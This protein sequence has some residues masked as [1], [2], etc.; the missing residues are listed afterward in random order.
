[1]VHW[2]R[3]APP[4]AR[5]RRS[6]DY[7]RHH[8]AQLHAERR[9]PVARPQR[10]HSRRRAAR[11]HRP[12]SGRRVVRI[13]PL[14]GYRTPQPRQ[15]RRHQPRNDGRADPRQHLHHSSRLRRRHAA[16]LQ[17]SQGGGELPGAGGAVPRPHRPRRRSRSR[18]R[19]AHQRGVVLS[20]PA[21]R[22]AALPP[23]GG[24]PAWLSQRQ[25][26]GRAPLRRG[27]CRPW[28]LDRAAGMVARLSRR[29]RRHG[30][31]HGAAIQLCPLLWPVGRAGPDDCRHVPRQFQTVRVPCRASRKRHTPGAL[32]RDQG[33]GGE[34]S[35]SAATSPG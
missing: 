15:P 16:P 31:G 4:I 3:P 9:R 11:D 30:R 21:Q 8:R 33:E 10:W 29:Q 28:H 24:R 2:H 23:T 34:S 20:A 12:R 19:P 35:R 7:R 27:A 17:L 25:P 5:R 18:Q 32:R 22:R 14:L 1:M 26:R 13:R 6:P